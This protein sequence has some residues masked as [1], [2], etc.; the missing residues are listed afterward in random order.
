MQEAL[1]S[2]E[3]TLCREF[4]CPGDLNSLPPARDSIM[5]LVEEHCLD[6]QKQI[7]IMIALQ[8]ALANAIVHGCGN[9]A[10]K[11]VSCTVEITPSAFTF[12]V[13]DPGPGFDTAGAADSTEDGTNLTQH[14]RGLY[15]IRSLMDEVSYRHH[16]SELVMKKFRAAP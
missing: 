8:E 15:L 3:P 13:R 4:L 1:R 2:I 6:E 9:D 10:R 5:Q 12:C 16:G 11:T 14:G 7:D